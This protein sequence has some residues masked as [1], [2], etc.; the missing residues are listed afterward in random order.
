MRL[1]VAPIDF[2]QAAAFVRLHHRHHTPPV[3]H[4]FSLAALLD[5]KLVGVAI[6]GRPVARG[7]DDG[8]TLEVTRLCTD[9]TKNA[10]SFL[11]GAA[12]RA[13]FALGY[14]RVGTYILKR[15]PGT[16]LAAAG[17]KLIGEVKGRSWSC[18]SRPRT[19]KHPTEPKLLFEIAA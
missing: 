13:A 16:S 18:Q 4:K 10:C 14:Q 12:A 19:D 2:D 1:S 15:E 5:G 7:R 9:G 6:I 8:L 17:W 3:G 11:Y